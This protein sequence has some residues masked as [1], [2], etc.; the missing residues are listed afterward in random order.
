MLWA[1]VIN[2]CDPRW[3]DWDTYY[4]INFGNNTV[5]HGFLGNVFLY[6]TQHATQV[7][8]QTFVGLG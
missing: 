6:N 8:I 1:G 2:D 4:I 5:L 7:A 3:Y